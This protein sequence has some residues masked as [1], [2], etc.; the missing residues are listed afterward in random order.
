LALLIRHPAYWKVTVDASVLKRACTIAT[1][2]TA[3]ATGFSILSALA[4]FSSGFW[5]F[6][7]TRFPSHRQDCR[8][9]SF[10]WSTTLTAS[11]LA[12]GCL[13]SGGGAKTLANS[14]QRR[15]S[16]WRWVFGDNVR[17]CSFLY[18]VS[19]ERNILRCIS[20][21]SCAS[22]LFIK[23]LLSDTTTTAHLLMCDTTGTLSR[24]QSPTHKVFRFLTGEQALVVNVDYSVCLP[25]PHPLSFS[26]PR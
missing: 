25:P 15:A 14:F 10:K 17:Q 21:R 18:S 11:V 9:T 6:I 8:R 16:R 19:I 4:L 22:A 20:A 2:P 23:I 24:Q 12:I 1:T 13:A 7:K 26:S 3:K 5:S